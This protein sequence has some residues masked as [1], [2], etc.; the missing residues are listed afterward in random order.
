MKDLNERIK[1]AEEHPLMQFFWK[2]VIVFLF[3]G[4]VIKSFTKVFYHD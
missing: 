1:E 4:W 3:L 2:Y